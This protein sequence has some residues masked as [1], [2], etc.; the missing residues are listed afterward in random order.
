MPEWAGQRCTGVEA[1]FGWLSGTPGAHACDT[2][3][4]AASISSNSNVGLSG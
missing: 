4:L 3:H 1:E 2:G